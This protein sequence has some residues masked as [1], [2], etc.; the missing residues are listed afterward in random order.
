MGIFV[1]HL[2]KIYYITVINFT[3]QIE[4]NCNTYTYSL[5]IYII[6][7]YIYTIFIPEKPYS[8]IF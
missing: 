1:L 7:Y 2:K 4:F 3:V 5:C 8:V 6:I